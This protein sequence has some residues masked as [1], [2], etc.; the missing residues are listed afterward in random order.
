MRKGFDIKYRI[1]TAEEVVARTRRLVREHKRQDGR[2]TIGF[3]LLST[4]S[5]TI[6]AVVFA[7]VYAENREQYAALGLKHEQSFEALTSNAYKLEL[8]K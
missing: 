8:V 3:E 6:W 2:R 4:Q 5:P 7:G 1:G